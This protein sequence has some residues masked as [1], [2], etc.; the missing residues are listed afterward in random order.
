MSV[1][2][3]ISEYCKVN[4]IKQV[5]L[6]EWSF[7]STQ[8]ISNIFKRKQNPNFEFIYKF[9]T[10][11]PEINAR[12]FITGEGDMLSVKGAMDKIDEDNKIYEKMICKE[13]DNLKGQLQTCMKEKNQLL[14]IMEN[15]TRTQANEERNAS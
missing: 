7:G 13:C 8:T 10:K 9:L 3:R 12:W 5:D 1:N 11:F 4:K 14:D 2:D 6:A 15:L